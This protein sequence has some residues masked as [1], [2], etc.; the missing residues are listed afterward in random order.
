MNYR[1]TD[2]ADASGPRQIPAEGKSV[3][4]NEKEKL[5]FGERLRELRAEKGLT[6]EETAE[7]LNISLRYYQMLE[8]GE[9]TGSVDILIALGDVLDCS[10]DYLLMGKRGKGNGDP[11]TAKLNALSRRQRQYAGKMLELWLESLKDR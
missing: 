9:K 3:K 5:L 4:M 11:L 1:Y 8:R 10:L 2:D 7:A 6:Q